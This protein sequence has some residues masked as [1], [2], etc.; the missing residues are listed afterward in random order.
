M[1]IASTW[2]RT[3]S[4]L[5]PPRVRLQDRVPWPCAM[6]AHRGTV[7]VRE[8]VCQFR[9][10]ERGRLRAELWRR[11]SRT[12]SK[13]ASCRKSVP[14]WTGLWIR[15]V[16]VRAQEGQLQRRRYF[17]SVGHPYVRPDCSG[18]CYGL[19]PLSVVRR[20]AEFGG[21]GDDREQR[22][23][24]EQ[25]REHGGQRRHADRER[26]HPARMLW[27]IRSR[28]FRDVPST[29]HY[30]CTLPRRTPIPPA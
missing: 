1:E 24:R 9:P 18:F 13:T 30:T 2:Y 28:S 25:T 10:A 21:I 20:F 4:G 17:D 19:A 7:N 8:L 22:H 27:R 12:G 26:Q 3:T 6:G 29:R 14:E 16:L 23:R 5:P 15:K 11:T